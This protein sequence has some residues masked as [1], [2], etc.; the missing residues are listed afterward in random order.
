MH[1]A[2]YIIKKS[3]SRKKMSLYGIGL[4][5]KTRLGVGLTYKKGNCALREFKPKILGLF[6]VLFSGDSGDFRG[7]GKRITLLARRQKSGKNGKP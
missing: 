7:I 3:M 4:L 6:G 5:I 1:E 2:I